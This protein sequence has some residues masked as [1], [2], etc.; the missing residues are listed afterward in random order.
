MALLCS[1]KLLNTNSRAPRLGLFHEHG[2]CFYPTL[3]SSTTH[4]SARHTQGGPLGGLFP[5]RN[6]FLPSPAPVLQL[7]E[8]SQSSFRTPNWASSHSSVPQWQ[9]LCDCPLA[10]VLQWLFYSHHYTVNPWGQSLCGGHWL[11]AK[12]PLPF[13]MPPTI[14]QNETWETDSSLQM[15]VC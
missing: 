4:C 9:A 13:P 10:P 15:G 12:Y 14:Q 8:D 11:T 3:C 5:P 2:L 6:A 7:A 1:Q